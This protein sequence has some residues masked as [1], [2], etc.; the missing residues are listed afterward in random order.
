MDMEKIEGEFAFYGFSLDDMKK[1]CEFYHTIL[2]FTLSFVI[3]FI[4]P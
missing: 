1:E 3:R 4:S 2:S